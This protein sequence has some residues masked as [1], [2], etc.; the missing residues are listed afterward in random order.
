TP[1]SAVGERGVGHLARVLDFLDKDIGRHFRREEAVLFPALEKHLGKEKG[2]TRL[3]RG[4]HEQFWQWHRQ[5]KAAYDKL[6]T[7]QGGPPPVELAEEVKRL[8]GELEGFLKEHIRKENETLLPLARRL[9]GE[10]EQAELARQW[11]SFAG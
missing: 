4:E 8:S 11:R 6:Q 3:L 1:G 7:A 5:L 9:F 10:A 2:P